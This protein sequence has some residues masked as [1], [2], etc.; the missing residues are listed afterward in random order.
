MQ[1]YCW[2][3]GGVQQAI[4]ISIVGWMGVYSRQYAFL[5]LAG[6]GCTAGNMQFYFWLAGGVQQF[7]VQFFFGW[8]GVCSRQRA[9]LRAVLFLAGWRCAAGNLQ[10]L[11]FAGRRV[12]NV[13]L[14]HLLEG[15]QHLMCSSDIF[16]GSVQQSGG[17]TRHLIAMNT[18]NVFGEYCKK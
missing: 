11:T 5:L 6:W 16:L 15:A 12:F 7:Y 18:S 17:F 4:C 2:L 10:L 3:D 14:K 13:Q 1:F 9:V 8:L